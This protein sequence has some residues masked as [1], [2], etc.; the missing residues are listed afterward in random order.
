[1][2]LVIMDTFEGQDNMVL[3]ELCE[4]NF[5]EVAIVPHNHSHKKRKDSLETRAVFSYILIL[6]W[7]I[8]DGSTDSTSTFLKMATV[9]GNFLYGNAFHVV[10]TIIGC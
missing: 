3:K 1:M 9:D 8:R 5:C 10:I 6:T 4:K 2:S 7:N